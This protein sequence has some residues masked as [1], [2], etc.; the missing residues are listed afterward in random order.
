MTSDT[1]CALATPPGVAGL[2]I[3]RVSGP[4]SFI[5]CDSFFRGSVS[6]QQASDH[7]IHFGWWGEGEQR[8]DSVTLMIYRS[9]RS[10][11]GEDVVEIG[12]HGGL[13][14]ADRIISDLLSAG[15]RLAEPG[16]FTRRAFLNKKLDLVQVEAVA[17][18]IHAESYRGAQVAARQLAG[19]FTERLTSFRAAL[20]EVVGLLE[21][22]LDFSEED[23]EFVSRDTLRTRLLAVDHEIRQ[24]A[25]SAHAASVLRS[26]FHV[27]V[28]GFPNAGKSSLFNALLLRDRAIVSDVPGTTR[29]YIRESILMDGYTVHLVDTAG[30]RETADTIE[31]EGIA[32]TRSL[33]DQADLVLVLND[34]S[35]GID[36]SNALI[37]DLQSRYPTTP[38]QLVHNKVDVVDASLSPSFHVLACSAKTGSGIDSLRNAI[39]SHVRSSTTNVT[40]VLVNA[41]QATLLMAIS[42]CLASVIA[43]LDRHASNDELAVDLRTSVRL[44]G[45]ITGETWNPDVLDTVFTRFCIG[46]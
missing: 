1:I 44:L 43:G 18:M 24:T 40:D 19:G 10:Y 37:N 14:V 9:P 12:C 30:I 42:D 15:A 20:L 17:D 25:S 11:T 4:R 35:L 16:E 41:R 5:V 45:E 8:V 39:L 38:I 46:K 7:T 28:V 29:D 33:I 3:I 23:V 32:I 31:L 6:A 26:G 22:E 34:L 27:A 2:A 21:L 36:H 13:F